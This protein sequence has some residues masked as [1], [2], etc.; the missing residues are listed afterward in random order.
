[1]NGGRGILN[2]ALIVLALALAG[3]L[4][5]MLNKDNRQTQEQAEQIETLREEARPYEKELQALAEE[6]EDLEDAVSYASETAEFIVGF[7]VTDVSDLDYIQEKA[8]AYLFSPVLV[9]DCTMERTVIEEIVSA[10]NSSWELML[11]APDYLAGVNDQ[12]LDVADYLD[13]VGREYTGVFFLREDYSSADSIQ[14]LAEDGFVGYTS[15]HSDSPRAGQ[16]ED[17]MVYFD[18]SYLSTSGTSVASRLSALYSNKAS[19]LVVL[20]M[21]SINS[22]KLTEAYVISL[23]D[24]LQSYA[25]NDDCSFSTVTEVVEELSK[26]NDIEAENQAG[27][28]A[29]AAELQ[30]RIAELEEIIQG[31]YDKLEE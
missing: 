6:L 30:E 26:I 1:M 2:A 16:L 31:I 23:F 7:V 5:F 17:G 12:I 28:E 19:M 8:A 21:A 18:Y 10:A 3:V 27:T 29:R 22:G 9:L 4:F 24:R 20:D 14:L 25:E 13:S 15:Y 11:Y